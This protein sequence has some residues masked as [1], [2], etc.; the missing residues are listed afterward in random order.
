MLIR[1]PGE[2]LGAVADQP[3]IRVE[4]QEVAAGGKPH[5][6]VVAAAHAEV[7]L[8][9]HVC[10][11]KPS[12]NELNRPVGRPVVDHDRFVIANALEAA[13]DPLR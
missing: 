8:L 13:L 5:P 10:L 2:L 9:D 3:G 11:G 6:S 12:P 7:L 1:K 4:Q